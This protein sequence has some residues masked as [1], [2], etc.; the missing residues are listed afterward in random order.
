MN[1]RQILRTG[2]L[3]SL[4]LLAARTFPTAL[5]QT[6]TPGANER[7]RIGIVG[8]SDRLRQA[9]MP[10]FKG[11]SGPFNCEIVGVSDLWSVRR[12]EAKAYFKKEMGIDVATYRNNEEL[13]EQAKPDAVII[14]TADFQ[15][16]LHATQAVQAGCDVYC[17]KPFAE[18]MADARMALKAVKESGKVF[19]VGSQR[20]SGS[21]YHAAHDYLKSGKFGPIVAAE[22]TWNVNQPGRWRRPDLVAKLRKEDIDWKRFLGN[23]PDDEWD[24]RKYLEYRLFWPYSSGIPGQWMCHQ[25]DTIHWFTGLPHPRSVSA[26]GGIYQWKDGRSNFDTL[27]AVF[28]Y[29]PL[30]DPT[31]GFQVVYSSRFS[32][33]AGGIKEVYYSNGGELNLDT[34]KVTPK[35]GLGDAEAAAMGMKG[36]R[37][38][39]LK[40]EGDGPA[41]ASAN[42]GADPMTSAHMRNW[43]ECLRSRKQ[44]HAPVEAGYQHSIATIM[45]NA[46]ARTG[47]RVTFDEKTQEVMAGGKVFHL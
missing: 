19:Q 12:D 36:N 20:R 3:G 9:L 34:G 10:A 42:T 37:L 15:H 35:G 16:A 24:P 23:R 13:Y 1:R 27:T 30:D 4:G 44:T 7:I 18:T 17:E 46:A 21:T 22:M 26:N 41:A 45:A 5:G 25:I 31:K 6:R 11:V 28:D 33:S 29:G 38:E 2:S 8:F 39:A 43:L 47:E 14:S 32:N 40:L